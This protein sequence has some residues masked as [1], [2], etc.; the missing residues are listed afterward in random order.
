MPDPRRP[1]PAAEGLTAPFWAAAQNGQLV[2]QRCQACRVWQQPP[3]TGCHACGA[4]PLAFEAVSGAARLFSWTVVRQG[5][6]AG[7]DDNL[8]YLVLVVELAEQAGLLMLSDM[9]FDESIAAKLRLDAPM[10]V[11][12]EQIAADYTL[13]Q[14]RFAS[15]EDRKA[16]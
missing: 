3:S 4:G 5:L 15:T 9:A 16:A 10:Q 2:V 8:P 14:F 7:F 1:R 12:F 11:W 6:A 13:P